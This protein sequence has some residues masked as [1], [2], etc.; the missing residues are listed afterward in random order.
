MFDLLFYL[1]YS[2]FS[3]I[4]LFDDLYVSICFAFMSFNR[5]VLRAVCLR[6][7]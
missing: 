7:S 6:L 1:F 2:S 5:P 4:F 3:F